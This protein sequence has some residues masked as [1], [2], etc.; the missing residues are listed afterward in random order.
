MQ[1]DRR[2]A[3]LVLLLAVIFSHRVDPGW[4]TG[5]KSARA[6]QEDAIYEAVVRRVGPHYGYREKKLLFVSIN[7]KDPKRHLIK[8]FAAI[9]FP[10]RPWSDLTKASLKEK[11][12]GIPLR[13]EVI[14][15]I[16]ETEVT[17]AWRVVYEPMNGSGATFRLRKKQAGWTVVKREKFWIT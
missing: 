3:P 17:V 5:S 6:S 11:R 10:A 15:W 13:V 7:G 16:S 8:R 2:I 4:G 9:H 12:E 1:M 14:H